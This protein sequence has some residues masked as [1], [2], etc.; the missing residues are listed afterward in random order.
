MSLYTVEVKEV[1]SIYYTIDIP[2]D[3][4]ED[5]REDYFFSNQPDDAAGS[6]CID[7]SIRS[8]EAK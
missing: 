3:I 4:P 6:E 8:M 7:Y 5:D 2:D 1:N